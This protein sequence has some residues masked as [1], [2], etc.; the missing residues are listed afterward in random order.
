M[1]CTISFTLLG[2]QYSITDVPLELTEGFD[3]EVTIEKLTEL[4]DKLPTNEDLSN[5]VGKLNTV[6][7]QLKSRLGIN[8]EALENGIF[9][10]DWGNGFVPLSAV[11][12]S[13]KTPNRTNH[14]IVNI[15]NDGDVENPLAVFIKSELSSENPDEAII[16][17]LSADI[18][19]D[20]GGRAVGYFD[21]NTRK[22]YIKATDSD[23]NEQHK[24]EFLAHE[25]IH[26]KLNNKLT[27]TNGVVE[28][29][30]WD[31][32]SL[33]T[34]IAAQ[35]KAKTPIPSKVIDIVKIIN[36]KEDNLLKAEELVAYMF[37]SREFQI[38]ANSNGLFKQLLKHLS[39]NGDLTEELFEPLIKKYARETTQEELD[40]KLEEGKEP[41]VQW[42]T[43]LTKDWPPHLQKLVNTKGFH[44]DGDNPFGMRPFVNTLSH[45]TEVE[46]YTEESNFTVK[47][48]GYVE[49]NSGTFHSYEDGE[50]SEISA[51]DIVIDLGYELPFAEP[52][53][54]PLSK[55]MTVARGYDK[56]TWKKASSTVRTIFEKNKKDDKNPYDVNYSHRYEMSKTNRNTQVLHLKQNDIVLLPKGLRY[57]GV[58]EGVWGLPVDA[59]EKEKESS[60]RPVVDT[61]MDQK[62]G[63]V[64]VKVAASTKSLKDTKATT[65]DIPASEIQG[66]RL[67][68]GQL[69]LPKLDK[70]KD[71]K[72]IEELVEELNREHGEKLPEDD[73][74]ETE[75]GAKS[76]AIVAEL[77]AEDELEPLFKQIEKGYYNDPTKKMRVYVPTNKNAVSFAFSNYKKEGEPFNQEP[78][79]KLFDGLKRGDTVRV[80]FLK[81]GSNGF[82][83]KVNQVYGNLIEVV[84]SKGKVRYYS[85]KDLVEI[86]YKNENHPELESFKNEIDRS[87]LYDS[88]NIEE[89]GLLKKVTTFNEDFKKNHKLEYFTG[90]DNVVKDYYDF[91]SK[92]MKSDSYKQALRNR[93]YVT[94]KLKQGDLIKITWELEKGKVSSA[95]YPVIGTTKNTVYFFAKSGN[96][97][98]VNIRAV[99]G[100]RLSLS[101]VAYNN[102]LEVQMFEEFENIYDEIKEIHSDNGSISSKMSLAA[103]EGRPTRLQ[104][105]YHTVEFREDRAEEE[106]YDGN[107]INQVKEAYAK[108]LRGDIVKVFT[109]QTGSDGKKIYKWR[110]VTDIDQFG[111]AITVAYTNEYTKTF[112]SGKTFDF[113]AG[114]KVY[115][116]NEED[117]VS[118]G[119]N[120]EQNDELGIVGHAEIRENIKKAE[121]TLLKKSKLKVLTKEELKA[122]K[123]QNYRDRTVEDAYYG[124][125]RGESRWATSPEYLDKGTAKKVGPDGKRRYWIKEANGSFV[126]ETKFDYEEVWYAGEAVGP[127]LHNALKVND[128]VTETWEYQGHRYYADA[129]I[130]NKHSG[131]LTVLRTVYDE[132]TDKISTVQK[133][134]FRKFDKTK[135]IEEYPGINSVSLAKKVRGYT[136]A[137]KLRK[138]I[139]ATRPNYTPKS[140]ET[141]GFKKSRDSREKII[142][143]TSMLKSVYGIPIEV[144]TAEELRSSMDLL[145]P[146]AS[147]TRA[148][149]YN[150]V[151]YI[152]SD[153]A[154]TA[155]PIHEMGHII[156][157][158]LQNNNPELYGALVSKIKTH[159]DYDLIAEDYSG[160]SED[161]LDTEVFVTLFGEHYRNVIHKNQFVE[162]WHKENTGLFGKIVTFVKGLFS[163]VFGV[164]SILD[165][166]ENDFARMSLDQVFNKFGDSLLNK[167][168]DHVSKQYTKTVNSKIEAL[169]VKLMQRD[170]LKITCYN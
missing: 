79:Q 91:K 96:V 44:Y 52:G 104:Q 163:K 93:E 102:T 115:P 28:D 134:V 39:S 87:F 105:I 81:K 5:V 130:I 144:L 46:I 86:T 3:Q 137:E 15:I 154:S 4:L 159:P 140:M 71:A 169:K 41:E 166:P 45:R 55:I 54:S 37:T 10:E 14:D 126:N 9:Q 157:A 36:S 117:I 168:F 1:A 31:L 128:I 82:R 112:E 129:I 116:V 83:V 120:L 26:R 98:H 64:Y 59:T 47:L 109:G 155:E 76:D 80:K 156:M 56:E 19:M 95:W 25:L 27:E 97:Q 67:Y 35:L 21:P 158:S 99:P 88:N 132:D 61:Y 8:A 74:S 40:T 23:L 162:N 22:V 121:E 139:S 141:T 78:I 20:G 16:S 69:V 62:T 123:F 89:N 153:L 29:V 94:S 114:Y 57:G 70:V 122:S 63:I 72:R 164:T 119:F 42:S 165:I 17:L 60:Y 24:L 53:E 77:D 161:E 145:V 84:T 152:N 34:K 167:K 32:T 103:K 51:K 149:V 75:D 125:K 90:S 49:S 138:D 106:G 148:F 118:V 12:N 48:K 13:S 124:E 65:F 58:S 101:A 113:Q 73:D 68:Q 108:V 43:K 136:A 30:I 146:D 133:N 142:A 18:E 111:R 127:T 107:T 11:F 135:A 151:V 110:M 2:T 66:Y 100:D 85:P 6:A 160:L 131:G 170:D 33:N 7:V 150:G 143:L 38:Y 50:T 147:D 92:D